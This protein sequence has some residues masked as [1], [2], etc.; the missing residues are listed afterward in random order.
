VYTSSNSK[1]QAASSKQQAA[2]SR[3]QTAD[4]SQRPVQVVEVH[5]V[6]TEPCQGRI[7]LSTCDVVAID[8]VVAVVLI[9]VLVLFLLPTS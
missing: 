1:Q 7:H 2:S 3:Q 8:V 9:V 5:V 4:S 6:G